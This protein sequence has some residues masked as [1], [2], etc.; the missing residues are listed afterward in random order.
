MPNQENEKLQKLYNGL[1]AKNPQ[2]KQAGYNNFK[3]QVQDDKNL[4]KIYNGLALKNPSVQQAGFEGFKQNLFPD[5][6]KK[7][8][9]TV[10]S[11][12]DGSSGSGNTLQLPENS[13]SNEMVETVKNNV[14]LA[15]YTPEVKEGLLPVKDKELTKSDQQLIQDYQSLYNSDPRALQLSRMKSFKN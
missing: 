4:K 14:S 5:G 9:S 6:V 8:E 1:S 2:L 7:K 12:P 10:G 13:T 3:Q 15:D 11:A